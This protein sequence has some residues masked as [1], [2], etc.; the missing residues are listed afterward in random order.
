MK[1]NDKVR[2]TDAAD[3]PFNGK[4]GSVVWC[5]EWSATVEVEIDG[6]PYRRTFGRSALA[7]LK[8]PTQ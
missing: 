3:G 1:N 8:E 5:N 4:I 6:L 2:V 7:R